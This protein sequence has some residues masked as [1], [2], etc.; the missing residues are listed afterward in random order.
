ML[1]LVRYLLATSIWF[2]WTEFSCL[3]LMA[4]LSGQLIVC[5]LLSGQSLRHGRLAARGKMLNLSCVCHGQICKQSPR[6]DGF[7]IRGKC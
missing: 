6:L 7:A 1:S 4:F 2:H 5:S 3:W